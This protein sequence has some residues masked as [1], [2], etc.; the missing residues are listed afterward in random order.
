MRGTYL[1]Q[2]HRVKRALVNIERVYAGSIHEVSADDCRDIVL[3]FFQNCYHLKDW[4]KND[5]NG[6]FQRFAVEQ[7]VNEN[8]ELRLCADICNGSKHLKLTKPPRSNESPRLGAQSVRVDLGAQRSMYSFVI[9]TTS[10]QIDA[11][12]LARECCLLWQQFIESGVTGQDREKDKLKPPQPRRSA[13]P[14]KSEL[15]MRFSEV[16][17]DVDPSRPLIYLWEILDSSGV[18]CCRY[19]GRSSGGADRPR[20]DYRRNVDNFLSGKPYRK[21]K[22]DDFRAIHRRMAQAVQAGESLRLSFICNVAA[23]EDINEVERF[24]Q[25]HHGAGNGYAP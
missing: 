13:Q 16:Q 11:L 2:V 6:A 24:W 20:T 22:P 23:D 17:G 18:V 5:A 10:D 1:E 4:L 15:Q 25:A 7:F 8:R 21:G 9:D 3:S 19:V 14:S 12:E